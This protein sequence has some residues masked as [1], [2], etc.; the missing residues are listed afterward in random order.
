MFLL[1]HPGTGIILKLL[2]FL[3]LRCLPGAV[4]ANASLFMPN[5][6]D[7]GFPFPASISSHL[8]AP[9]WPRR[10]FPEESLENGN[11]VTFILP[12]RP[13]SVPGAVLA[14]GVK[15]RLK[16]QNSLPSW[17]FHL[18]KQMI[19]TCI[20]HLCAVRWCTLVGQSR[21][22]GGGRECVCGGVDRKCEGQWNFRDHFQERP[23]WACDRCLQSNDLWWNGFGRISH[24]VHCIRDPGREV[25]WKKR[26]LWR[27]PDILE[28]FKAAL[29]RGKTKPHIRKK[30]YS[31]NTT[32][33][34]VDNIYIATM[35]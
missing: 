23:Q 22:G 20:K 8:I 16:R 24:T 11:G 25:R 9:N 1:C 35:T 29:E 7:T 3:A 4:W 33:L 6:R 12:G 17:S 30:L 28:H 13:Y 14:L 19:N 2:F 31:Q 15:Q 26:R 34:P 18:G 5:R 32:W 21:S 10:E 27:L